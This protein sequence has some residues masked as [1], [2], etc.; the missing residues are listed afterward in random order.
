MVRLLCSLWFSTHHYPE[1]IRKMFCF[2][3]SEF[4]LISNRQET[5]AQECVFWFLLQFSTLESSLADQIN[6]LWFPSQRV[7]FG[8]GAIIHHWTEQS[9][10]VRS[11]EFV[12]VYT[13]ELSTGLFGFEI[14]RKNR[15]NCVWEISFSVFD[16]FQQVLILIRLFFFGASFYN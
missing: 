1:R 4:F 11:F 6:S 10:L 3:E 8:R 14:G 7:S 13:G 5:Q 15:T 2:W 16:E 9:R 12:G